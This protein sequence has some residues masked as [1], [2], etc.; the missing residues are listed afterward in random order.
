MTTMNDPTTAAETVHEPAVSLDIQNLV[1]WCNDLLTA[2]ISNGIYKQLPLAARALFS[3]GMSL[4]EG[5]ANDYSFDRRAGYLMSVTALLQAPDATMQTVATLRAALL[6][7]D[8]QLAPLAGDVTPVP[9]ELAVPRS[10]VFDGGIVELDADGAIT[11][12]GRSSGREIVRLTAP[13]AF[14]LLTFLRVPGVSTLIEE[15]EAARQLQGWERFE[16]DPETI[17]ERAAQREQAR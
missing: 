15:T 17:A 3:A 12:C 10:H 7:A 6:A 9:R 16:A 2:T 8:P 13:E 14:E 1:N 11:I 5:M 4:A